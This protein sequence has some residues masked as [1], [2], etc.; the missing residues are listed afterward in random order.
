MLWSLGGQ[1]EVTYHSYMSMY[2]TIT[3]I[4]HYSLH[5][6]GDKLQQYIA[7]TEQSSYLQ[8]RQLVAAT[9]CGDMLQQKIVCVYW[10]IFVKIFASAT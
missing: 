7:A 1:T 6:P 3:V 5:T 8:V 9:H 4:I 10:K 2:S